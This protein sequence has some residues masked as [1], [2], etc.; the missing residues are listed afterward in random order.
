MRISPKVLPY[1]CSAHTYV[2]VNPVFLNH[3]HNAPYYPAGG[4][5]E[6][7]MFPG[8]A[9]VPTYQNAPRFGAGADFPQQINYRVDP[10]SQLSTQDVR[11]RKN[12]ADLADI[13]SAN[14]LENLAVALNNPDLIDDNFVIEGH[15]SAEGS[16]EY[17]RILSQERANS[18]F[19]FL[20]SRGVDPA[21]L[22]SVGHGEDMAR[23]A[24]SDP[25]YLRA[26]DRRVVVF[27]LAK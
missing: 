5:A 17:N 11:F 13:E 23:Y 1:G 3:S 10:D 6:A 19:S 7:A 18:V 21:R 15:A 20:A 14:F 9:P 22:L 25:E 26:E 24:A 12:S 27:K 8:Y 16:S 4:Y 2:G